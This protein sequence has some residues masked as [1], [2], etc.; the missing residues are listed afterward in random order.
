MLTF[1]KCEDTSV[2]NPHKSS[3]EKFPDVRG[4]DGLKSIAV[5]DVETRGGI[6]KTCMCMNGNK[7]SCCMITFSHVSVEDW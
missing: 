6:F 5:I 4:T 2:L 3:P 7:L 1:I